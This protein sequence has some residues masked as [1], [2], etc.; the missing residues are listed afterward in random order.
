[1]YAHLLK[2]A[3]SC[4]VKNGEIRYYLSDGRVLVVKDGEWFFK[5]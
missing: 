1:M 5:K 3:R 4:M 2:N